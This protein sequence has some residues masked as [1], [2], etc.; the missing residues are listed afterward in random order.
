MS[1]DI[2]GVP[3][4][5]AASVDGTVGLE[6][7][8]AVLD[9]GHARPRAALRGAARRRA[10]G[11]PAARATRSPA[12]SSPRR[13]RSAR[14]AGRTSPTRSPASASSAAGCSRSRRRA[15]SRSGATGT[16]PWADYRHQRN[17]DTEHY[18]RVVEGLQYVA[19]RNN[20]F[21][22]HVHVGVRDI[23]RAVRVCDRLR[24]VLPLLL[25]VSASSPFLDGLDSR[26]ALRP[27]ADLHAQLPALRHPR[28]L[29]LLGGLPRLHRLPRGHALDRRVHAGLVVDPAALRLRHG[30]GAHLRRPADGGRERGAVGPDRRLRAA[31]RARRRRGRPVPRPARRASSRRTSGARS[32]SGWTAS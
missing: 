30:R 13:S 32:A 19:R 29:R 9:P 4:V 11:R 17:I 7:E 21:S 26:P 3:D 12:S 24:P 16:H 18:R 31:G 5:F 8:F 15:A 14:A 25:A 10:G 20:T 23:D 6:E 27:H 22:L 28:R 2:A 1:L